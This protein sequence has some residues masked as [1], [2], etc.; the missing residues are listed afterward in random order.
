MLSP[1]S[2]NPATLKVLDHGWLIFQ[3]IPS[4]LTVGMFSEEPLEGQNRTHKYNERGHARQ[5]SDLHRKLD[6][7]KRQMERSDPQILIKIVGRRI[8]K[9]KRAQSIP[10][11]NILDI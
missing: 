3:E 5:D 2:L 8:Q 11:C 7:F 4:T 10:N 6:C 1:Y 9:K